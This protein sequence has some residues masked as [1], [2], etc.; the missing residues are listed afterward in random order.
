[1][2]EA[3]K[4]LM[5]LAGKVQMTAEERER[6]RMSFAYGSA[7]IENGSITEEMVKQASIKI[8]KEQVQLDG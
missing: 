7:K 5:A 8:K 1:M 4:T 6:Q 3:L 2:T